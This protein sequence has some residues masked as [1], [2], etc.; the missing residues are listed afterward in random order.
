MSKPVTIP[1]KLAEDF[2]TVAAHYRLKEFGEYEE[3]KQCVRNDPKGAAL[4][5]AAMANEIRSLS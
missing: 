3:A 4:S 1:R 5:Y 2:E